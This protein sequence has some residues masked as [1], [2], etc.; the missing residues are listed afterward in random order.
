MATHSSIL[1]WEIPW[2]EEP[3]ELQFTGSRDKGHMHEEGGGRCA[4]DNALAVQVELKQNRKN[5]LK[6]CLGEKLDQYQP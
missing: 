5:F 4:G 1:A 6:R 3:G 2:T